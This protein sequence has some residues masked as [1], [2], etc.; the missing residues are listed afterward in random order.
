MRVKLVLLSSTL[1]VYMLLHLVVCILDLIVFFWV[2]MAVPYEIM[3][4]VQ[5]MLCSSD[6]AGYCSIISNFGSC[7]V[8]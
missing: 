8:L 6:S 7:F 5:A 4:N 3:F 1:V 2:G